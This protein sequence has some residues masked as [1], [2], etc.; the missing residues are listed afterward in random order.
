MAGLNNVGVAPIRLK[1]RKERI[2]SVL[3]A[4]PWLPHAIRRKELEMVCQPQADL[5]Q[6][7]GQESSR[8]SPP[9]LS[10]RK[11]VICLAWRWRG[12]RQ[13]QQRRQGRFSSDPCHRCCL[14]IPLLMLDG[15]PCG[16][17]WRWPSPHCLVANKLVAY[18]RLELRYAQV[19]LAR[20]ER[21]GVWR[22]RCGLRMAEF[23]LMKLFWLTVFSGSDRKYT[24]IIANRY[25]VIFFF[26][27][28][29]GIFIRIWMAQVESHESESDEHI[30]LNR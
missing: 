6:Q 21:A 28:I 27:F 14:L 23:I 13:H 11:Q 29:W 25:F 2:I 9:R 17:C 8:I 10:Y 19:L 22:L 3:L 12:G 15:V 7:A 5:S 18:M 24:W 20:D 16:S 1:R 30:V 26:F 4:S